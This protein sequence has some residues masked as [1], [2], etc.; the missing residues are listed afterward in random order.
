MPSCVGTPAR[1]FQESMASRLH[2]P[3]LNFGHMRLV[4]TSDYLTM[5]GTPCYRQYTRSPRLQQL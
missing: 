3:H 4:F 5:W 1:D 2:F